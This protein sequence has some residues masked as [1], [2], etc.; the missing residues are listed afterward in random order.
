VAFFPQ[1]AAGPIVRA[2]EFLPQMVSPP[3]PTAAQVSVGVQLIAMGLFKKLCIADHLDQLFVGPV[4]ADPGRYDGGAVRWAMV[5]WAVQIY[6]DFSGYTDMAAGIAKWFG[7]EFPPNFDRPYLATSITDFWRRWHLSL[8]TWLRDYLYFPLGGS[9]GGVGRTYANLI[10]V[11]ILCGLWHGATG[12]WLVYG[13]VNGVL[14]CAHRA[15][16]QNLAG[17]AWACE[18]RRSVPWAV[19]AWFATML[20][21]I[22]ALVL[23]RMP[24]W[25]AGEAMGR[26]ALGHSA[27]GLGVPLWVPMLVGLGLA[28]HLTTALGW[29]PRWPEGVRVAAVVAAIVA[30]I[31]L[32]PGVGQTF[33]YIQ[34]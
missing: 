12:A 25:A 28:G 34:F 17:R 13:L 8:S 33:I 16:D 30:V 31:T 32:G 26:A 1:M 20:Q 27:G 22:G 3:R 23:I 14:M 5:A 19:L 18:V 9:R 6:C 10:L 21:V 15:F 4:F 7:F 29:R 2:V 24:N 11:F